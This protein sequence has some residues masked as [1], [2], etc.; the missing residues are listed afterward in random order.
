MVAPDTSGSGSAKLVSFIVSLFM[1]DCILTSLPPFHTPG[2][3][4]SPNTGKK[5]KKK[6]KIYS[7]SRIRHSVSD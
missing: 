7:L 5:K 4:L 1:K 6:A 3:F 2:N